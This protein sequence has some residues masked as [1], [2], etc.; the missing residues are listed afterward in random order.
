MNWLQNKTI[1]IT[2]SR[3]QSTEEI[4]TLE[5]YGAR[6]LDFSTIKISQ[7]KDSTQIDNTIT[8]LSVYD[9]IIFSSVNS[10]KYFNKRLIA[11]SAGIPANITIICV[12]TQTEE[13]AESKNI[14]VNFVPKEYSAKG[15]LDELSKSDIKNK[16]FL[17]PSSTIARKEL[18]ESLINAGAKVDLV[19]VYENLL[20]E[21]EEVKDQL[22]K[23][24]I[25]KMDAFIFSSP[26]SFRNLLALAKIE[27]AV[28]YFNDSVVTA[29][30]PTTK[31]EIENHNVKVDLMPDEFTIR[32]CVDLLHNYDPV[33]NMER[34]IE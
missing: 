8:Q 1:L 22:I 30:G 12:G 3:K 21:I 34:K 14:N 28:R 25:Q 29:I 13:Y 31:S 4:K 24:K 27:D 20:P 26:S 23:L 19:P 7:V 15:I 32:A 10:I 16:H 33:Y 17:I 18:S 9:F 5:S 11:Q 2:R 6:V